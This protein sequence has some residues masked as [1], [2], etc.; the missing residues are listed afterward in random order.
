[1]MQSGAFAWSAVWSMTAFALALWIAV[2]IRLSRRA[3]VVERPHP[4]AILSAVMV[5]SSARTAV[6]Q[7]PARLR[8]GRH[9]PSPF[10]TTNSK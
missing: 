1:M 5:A 10:D 8:R 9:T 3:P 4:W 2:E 6:V 7:G